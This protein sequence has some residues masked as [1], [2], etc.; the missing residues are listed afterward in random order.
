MKQG[1]VPVCRERS[2]K[3]EGDVFGDSMELVRLMDRRKA[4]K[5]AETKYEQTFSVTQRSLD[6]IL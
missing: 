5:W 3:E 1:I 4:E 6:S 2:S